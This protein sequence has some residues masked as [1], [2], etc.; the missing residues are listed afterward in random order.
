MSSLHGCFNPSPDTHASCGTTG[1]LAACAQAAGQMTVEELYTA[2]A[3]EKAE[4]QE[5][6]LEL[7]AKEEHLV[8]AAASRWCVCVC[9]CVSESVRVRE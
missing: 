4:L 6:D 5:L 2:I 9:V 7:E 1:L 8:S 3:V